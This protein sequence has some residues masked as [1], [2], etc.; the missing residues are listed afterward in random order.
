[1]SILNIIG[2]QGPKP[3]AQASG[4]VGQVAPENG[5]ATPYQMEQLG[6]TLVDDTEALRRG[7][8]AIQGLPVGHYVWKCSGCEWT[9]S[10]PLGGIEHEAFKNHVKR[11]AHAHVSRGE[12]RFTSRN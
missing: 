3:N 1:M 5:A 2:Q 9:Q 7:E 8:E 11:H 4:P 12:I 10:G 6:E